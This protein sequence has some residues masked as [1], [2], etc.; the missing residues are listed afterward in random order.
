MA[1]AEVERNELDALME[2][3]KSIEDEI[4][5][6]KDVLESVSLVKCYFS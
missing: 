2:K 4:K 5:E 6:L 1:A 3:K